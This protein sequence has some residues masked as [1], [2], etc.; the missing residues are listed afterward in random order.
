M[1]GWW[2]VQLKYLI[3]F[4]SKTGNKDVLAR[5]RRRRKRTKIQHFSLV[6]RRY[7]GIN[8]KIKTISSGITI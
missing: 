1:L 2:M 6:G 8:L 4:Q 5:D 7:L 3:Q